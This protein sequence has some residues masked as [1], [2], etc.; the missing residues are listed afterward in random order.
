MT[1]MYLELLL[2]ILV[3][4]QKSNRYGFCQD[5]CL[6]MLLETLL[7]IFDWKHN[8]TSPRICFGFIFVS[9]SDTCLTRIIMTQAEEIKLSSKNTENLIEKRNM[10]SVVASKM[11]TKS[12]SAN[13]IY[14]LGMI[15]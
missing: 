3:F 4:W 13:N 15:S 1:G 10:S 8:T 9:K 11:P 12:S 6:G 14:N 2:S 7:T 5:K